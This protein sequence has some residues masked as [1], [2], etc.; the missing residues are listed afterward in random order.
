MQQISDPFYGITDPPLVN[1]STVEY[2]YVE[3]KEK[4]VTVKDLTK[5]EIA[6]HNSEMW[7]HP[8]NS[9]LHVRGRILKDD[10]NAMGAN[11]NAT[12][13]NNGFN[14]FQRAK[15]FV[16]D[17][18]IEDIE[19]VGIATSVLNLVEFSDDYARS[20]AQNM[21]W[22]K[23]TADSTSYSRLLYDAADKTT[24]VKD[25]ADTAEVFVNAIKTNHHFNEGFLQRLI[26]TR[27]SKQVSLFL[28]I[29]RLF[30]FCKD[31]NRVFKG[32]KHEIQLEKNSD[33]NIIHK[34]GT[35]NYKFELNH[36]SWWIPK[37]V[38]SLVEMAK[39]ETALASGFATEL[40][41]ESAKVYKSDVKSITDTEVDW[42]VTSFHHRPS[43]IFIIF[44]NQARHNSQSETN[45]IF[46]HMDLERL[47][48]KL[49]DTKQYP[50]NE[51]TCNF[52]PEQRDYSRVYTSFLAAGLKTHDVDTGT[53]VSYSDFA[54][55]FPIFHIDVSRRDTQIY[56]TQMTTTINVQYKL[57]TAPT[58][59]YHVYC[60]VMFERRGLLKADD[61]KLF[62]IL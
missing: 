48:V 13:T 14:L 37:V 53:V 51:L 27:N 10:G 30:G 60:I 52:T 5:Y 31:I 4:N 2:E 38:P 57:R 49:N 28:P 61:R 19:N 7:I 26:L 32:V 50:D 29:S 1:D 46:D 59:N 35:L 23:D 56:E 8:R 18:E 58:S 9:F 15:Y 39:L 17:K 33:N 42:S 3:L 24:P 20:A 11:D 6:T 54:R 40:Y 47:R 55:L 44:Q 34:I 25:L 43:H 45:M 41:W 21:W 22:Y 62:V 36:L 12:L 16:E